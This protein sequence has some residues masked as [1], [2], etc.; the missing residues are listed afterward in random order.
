R[1]DGLEPLTMLSLASEAA[2]HL[3]GS[4][5]ATRCP[6]G[7]FVARKPHLS[8]IQSGKE[9]IFKAD[10]ALRRPN[11]LVHPPNPRFWNLPED[12]AQP[13]W[14]VAAGDGRPFGC[15]LA[16]DQEIREC[17]RLSAAGLSWSAQ[18]PGGRARGCWRAF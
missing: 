12:R 18:S 16:Y 3:S 14:L 5:R 9:K 4:D 1:V 13:A 17:W 11:F 15:Q 7:V 2:G 6:T 8:S 10:G